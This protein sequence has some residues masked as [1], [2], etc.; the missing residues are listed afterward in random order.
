M[1]ACKIVPVRITPGNKAAIVFIHGGGGDVSETWG[2]FPAFLADAQELG[3][4]DIYSIGYESHVMR[5]SDYRNPTKLFTRMDPG[6]MALSGWLAREMMIA[7]LNRYASIAIVSHSLCGLSAQRALLDDVN[8]RERVGHLFLFGVSSKGFRGI[9]LDVAMKQLREIWPGSEFI[10]TLRDNWDYNFVAKEAPLKY[11]AIAGTEDGFVKPDTSVAPFPPE[12]RRFVPGDH[13][14]MVK[15]D[16][17]DNAS[18]LLVIDGIT[19]HERW[20]APVDSADIAVETT[21][22]KRTIARLGTEPERLDHKALV[23]LGIAYDG[24]GRRDEAMRVLEFARGKRQTDAMG[25]LAGRYKRRWLAFEREHDAVEASQLYGDGL[26]QSVE[27]E[28]WGQACYHGI[29]VAFM[30]LAYEGKLPAARAQASTVLEYCAKCPAD[31]WRHAS[32]GEAH[33][34]LDDINASL[35]CYAAAIEHADAWEVE[36]MFAQATTEAKL[37]RHD[38]F[39]GRLTELCRNWRRRP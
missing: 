6:V 3:R 13:I 2:N 33:L 10:T 19:N 12:V 4:W 15:P 39:I 26:R 34:L 8:L 9:L 1:S 5:L 31:K 23:K 38:E 29:N 11:W 24:V 27:A 22:F 21:E 14:E 20:T 35:A 25:T 7:P 17:A 18:V 16:S 37:L 32:E 28:N 30:M 36:S